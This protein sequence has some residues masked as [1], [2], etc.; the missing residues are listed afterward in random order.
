M[1]YFLSKTVDELRK[2]ITARYA[3]QRTRRMQF[4]RRIK[5]VIMTTTKNMDTRY[6]YFHDCVPL[7]KNRSTHIA[8][9]V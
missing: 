1:K 5:Y 2:T 6:S 7:I 9:V 4:E 8:G 3:R